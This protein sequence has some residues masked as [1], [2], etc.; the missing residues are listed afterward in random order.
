MRGV[1]DDKQL[2]NI[3]NKLREDERIF[4]KDKTF[5]P[6]EMAEAVRFLRVE[7]YDIGFSNGLAEGYDDA[8]A[9]WWNTYLDP[10]RRGRPCNYLFAG[11]GWNA[12]NFYPNQDIKP[13][14]NATALF[15]RFSWNSSYPN[16]DLAQRLEECGVVLDVSGAITAADLFSNA[17][18]TRVPSLNL[19]NPSSTATALTRVFQD[20]RY[21]VTIDELIIRE[22]GTNTFPQTFNGC[23]ALEN[24]K[25]T[26]V[27]GSSINFS[28]SPLT[29]ASMKSIVKHLKDFRGTDNEYS[30]TLTVAV[31][32]MD[33]LETEGFIEEDMQWI[34]ENG[35]EWEADLFWDQIIDDLRWNL[36]VV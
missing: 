5:Y 30:C 9:D 21:L 33:A 32:S 1:I 3:A 28:N 36:V 12:N 8:T 14:D 16:I 35:L 6:E 34:E 26:G 13:L 29:A 22:D 18:V 17:F 2:K 7:S 10:M 15:N 27:I 19:S 23:T 25:F 4:D 31:D 11:P 24:V 20:A